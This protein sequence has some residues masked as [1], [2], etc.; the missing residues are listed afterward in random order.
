MRDHAGM[1]ACAVEDR[2]AGT[3]VVYISILIYSRE[4]ISF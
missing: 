3:T 4:E 1:L 2:S